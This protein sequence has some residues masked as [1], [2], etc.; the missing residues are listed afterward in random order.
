MKGKI[1][2]IIKADDSKSYLACLNELVDE[3]NNTYH[4]AIV[5]KPDS[6]I[7]VI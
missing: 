7:L 3:Y 4:C 5:K 1:Y 6:I 2:K